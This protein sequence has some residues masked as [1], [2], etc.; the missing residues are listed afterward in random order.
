MLLWLS[1]PS[2]FLVVLEEP[3]PSSFTFTFTFTYGALRSQDVFGA[4]QRSTFGARVCMCA[5]AW[6]L[7]EGGLYFYSASAATQE[8]GAH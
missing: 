3:N 8:L 6:I 1:F 7:G 2:G 5:C 4:V